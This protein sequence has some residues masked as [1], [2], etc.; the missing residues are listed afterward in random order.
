M[1]IL[2]RRVI[3]TDKSTISNLYIDGIAECY[4]LED[5]DRGID[6]SMRLDEIT[7]IKVWGETAIPYGRYKV[8]I[9]KSERFSKLAGKDVFLPQILNVPGFEGVRV[10]S[11]NKPED[12]EGC[13]LPGTEKGLNLVKNSRTAYVRIEDKINAAIKRGEEVWITVTKAPG[14]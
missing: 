9:T 11:G 14:Q 12:T 2:Q 4:I 1:E 7:K 8:A 6:A 13:L 10:H 5:V 3:F